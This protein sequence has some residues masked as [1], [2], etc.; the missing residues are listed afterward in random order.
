MILSFS[1]YEGDNC[2]YDDNS[3]CGG[4]NYISSDILTE[5]GISEKEKV[6]SD[7][8]S[9]KSMKKVKIS[10]SRFDDTLQ[11]RRRI[12]LRDKTYVICEYK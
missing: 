4:N 8:I 6:N 12:P 5:R 3:G 10:L 11:K 7:Y 1:E 9:N 2:V